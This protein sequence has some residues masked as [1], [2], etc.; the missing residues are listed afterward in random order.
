MHIIQIKSKIAENSSI[1]ST[2]R[3]QKPD[4]LDQKFPSQ[5]LI[6]AYFWATRLIPKTQCLPR[7]LA[8]YSRLISQN[9]HVQHKIGV[10]KVNGKP[11]FHAWV[12]HQG[13]A[14]N[15]SQKN[16]NQFQE[17]KNHEKYFN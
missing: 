9:H 2:I 7:S 11:Y 5:E 12:E 1:I 6:K 13:K 17:L 16:I 8:L 10:R 4:I 3:H 15:E 14:L